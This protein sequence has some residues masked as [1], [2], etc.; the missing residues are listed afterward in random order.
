MAVSESVTGC[1]VA[2]RMVAAVEGKE[3]GDGLLS[4]GVGAK[5][6]EVATKVVRF[7]SRRS[8]ITELGGA[9]RRKGHN[10]MLSRPQ[11]LL[12]SLS[13][14]VPQLLEFGIVAPAPSSTSSPIELIRAH[15]SDAANALLPEMVTLVDA[16]GFTDWELDTTVS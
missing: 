16:F 14:A 1:Y 11:Y 7:V 6:K 13:R 2:K 3:K 10:L 15:L 9:S 4:N 5:E 12:N 8:S